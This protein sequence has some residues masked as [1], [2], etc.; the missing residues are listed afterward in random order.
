MS[1]KST[2]R[3]SRSDRRVIAVST[4]VGESSL[5][6]IVDDRSEISAAVRPKNAAA[7]KMAHRRNSIMKIREKNH[8]NA[9]YMA[10]H[11]LQSGE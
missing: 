11:F 2:S 3:L 6:S 1:V 8:M 5:W 10:Y 9:G 7:A 4:R